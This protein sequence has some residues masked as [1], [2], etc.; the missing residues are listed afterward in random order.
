MGTQIFVSQPVNDL[1]K[2]KEFFIK[3]GYTINPQFSDD[4]GACV[5]ISDTIYV[6]LVTRT[7]FQTF[8]KKEVV[9]ASTG[10][11]RSV[12]LSADSKDAVNEMV[13]T[14]L[15]AG[16]TLTEEATD[17]GFMYMH[18]FDDLDGHHWEYIWMD[19]NGPPPH[20]G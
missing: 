10:V 5:V 6:M 7:F 17:Y 15:A 14:A 1:D 3:L 16:A 12:S 2:S 20:Q 4:K 19:P 13:A 18:G 9:D 11:E 8:T